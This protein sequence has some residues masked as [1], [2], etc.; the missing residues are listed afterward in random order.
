MKMQNEYLMKSNWLNHLDDLVHRTPPHQRVNM[1]KYL[2]V[3]INGFRGFPKC[4]QDRQIPVFGAG[5]NEEN[6]WANI[7][8]EIIHESDDIFS[9]SQGEEPGECNVFQ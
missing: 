5:E 4:L 2:V 8:K 9:E 3:G 1:A 7:L 6:T